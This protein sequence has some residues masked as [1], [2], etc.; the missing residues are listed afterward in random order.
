MWFDIVGTHLS[1]TYSQLASGCKIVARS[2]WITC[3]SVHR[4]GSWKDFDQDVVRVLPESG[5]LVS[6]TL[7]LTSFRTEDPCR[8]NFVFMKKSIRDVRCFIILLG[9]HTLKISFPREIPYDEF[10]SKKKFLFLRRWWL[11]ISGSKQNK[12]VSVLQGIPQSEVSTRFDSLNSQ[13]ERWNT[14]IHMSDSDIKYCR[15]IRF[16]FWLE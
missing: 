8:T 15:R 7:S 14:V 10:L 3:L 11:K 5:D 13:D 1:S 6:V 16:F 12:R 2:Y 4:P 9:W